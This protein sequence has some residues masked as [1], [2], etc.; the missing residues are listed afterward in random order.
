M[1]DNKNTE[2]FLEFSNSQIQE[3]KGYLIEFF[4]VCYLT[5]SLRR[6]CGVVRMDKDKPESSTR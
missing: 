2:I 6:M 4:F 3:R 5:S 1:V